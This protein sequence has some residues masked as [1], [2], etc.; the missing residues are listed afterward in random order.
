MMSVTENLPA[1][2]EVTRTPSE[3][4]KEYLDQIQLRDEQMLSD[5]VQ[6]A[7]KLGLGEKVFSRLLIGKPGP[8]ILEEV[9]TSGF[10]L[11]VIG[12]RGLSG[13]REMVLGS[14]SKH[15]VDKS[16]I[17]VLVVKHSAERARALYRSC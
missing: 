11:I 12:D 5:A 3:W 14:V 2:P 17:P 15:V 13:L 9:S 10:D 1:G 7:R 16:N 6:T 8:L 4:V